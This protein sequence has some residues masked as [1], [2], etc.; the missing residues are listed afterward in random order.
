[1]VGAARFELT[2][3]CSQNKNLPVLCC[4]LNIPYEPV[5]SSTEEDSR[6]FKAPNTEQDRTN[7][8]KKSVQ[9]VSKQKFSKTDSRYWKARLFKNSFTRGDDRRETADFCVK[10]A[11]AGRRET[12]NLRTSNAEAAAG[13]ARDFYRLLLSDGWDAA[14]ALYK[15]RAATPEPGASV[16]IGD[17]ISAAEQRS[18]HLRPTTLRYY[19]GCLRQ[20]AADIAGLE[21]ADDRHDYVG[22]GTERWRKTVDAIPLST[23]TAASV[24]EWQ[25]AYVKARGSSLD[26]IR[27]GKTSANTIVGSAARMF[28]EVML[29][30]YQDAGLVVAGNPF[31]GVKPFPKAD[32]RYIGTI[33]PN[34]ILLA[35]RREFVESAP[36]VSPKVRGVAVAHAT[37]GLA[38]GQQVYRAIL[39]GTLTGLRRSELDRLQW[40]HVNFSAQTLTVQSTADGSVKASASTRDI[41]LAP[42]LLATLAEWKANARSVYVIECD[43]SE[44]AKG[45]TYRRYRCARV[46]GKAGDWLRKHFMPGENHPLH[47]LRKE[48]GSLITQ[49]AGIHAAKD[50]LGHQDIRTTADFYVVRKARA[51]PGLAVPGINPGTQWGGDDCLLPVRN[52]TAQ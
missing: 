26:A 39:L 41:D 29:A 6:R 35:A 51:L 14:V 7:M 21:K 45:S 36:V 44:F 42:D 23:I 16:T 40:A 27:S 10:I 12:V 30:H 33:D 15:P 37:R 50:L 25:T 18:V 13:K 48:Y 17:L 46:F 4:S 22:G 9:E 5:E 43:G 52:G 20:I 24:R 8:N 49:A 38:D 19:Q 32:A 2:T 3:S 11:H 34:A 28:T 47:T 31:A 1:M